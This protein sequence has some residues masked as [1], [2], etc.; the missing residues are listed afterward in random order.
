[1]AIFPDKPGLAGSI[2][3]KDD[4]S[5]GDKCSYKSCNPTFYRPSALPVAQPSVSIEQ[6][7]IFSVR[8]NT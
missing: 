6:K 5:V 2:E 3:A 7:R 4:G 8:T 1:M